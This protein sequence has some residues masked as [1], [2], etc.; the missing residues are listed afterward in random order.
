MYEYFCKTYTHSLEHP[1]AIEAHRRKS[2][3]DSSLSLA[4]LLWHLDI[5]S[6]NS[7]QRK[8]IQN[9]KDPGVLYRAYAN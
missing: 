1:A 8:T 9:I 7:Q 5:Q 2:D 3:G 6:R 4:R